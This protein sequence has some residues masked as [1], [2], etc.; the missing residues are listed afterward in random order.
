MLVIVSL[1]QSRLD[2]PRFFGPLFSRAGHV[3][4]LDSHWG[5]GSQKFGGQCDLSGGY[6]SVSF[7]SHPNTWTMVPCTEW[8]WWQRQQL[9]TGTGTWAVPRQCSCHRIHGWLLKQ[10]SAKSSSKPPPGHLPG[11]QAEQRLFHKVKQ[12]PLKGHSLLWDQVLL[13]LGVK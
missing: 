8:S 9:H 1:P 13:L 3:A 12:I 11:Q 5:R 7:S 10:P 2:S 4:P 6:L